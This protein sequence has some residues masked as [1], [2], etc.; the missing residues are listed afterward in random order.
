MA[1]RKPAKSRQPPVLRQWYCTSSR[2]IHAASNAASSPASWKLTCAEDQRVSA[3]SPA[4]AATS[5]R[6]P[7]SSRASRRGPVTGE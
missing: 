5:A 3:M 7:A 6:R 4:I 2:G 1:E